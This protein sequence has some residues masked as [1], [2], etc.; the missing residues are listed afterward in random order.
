MGAVTGRAWQNAPGTPPRTDPGDLR[1]MAED[2]EAL[3]DGIVGAD[4]KATSAQSAAGD[5]T[6]TAA[7]AQT[8]A[9]DAQAAAAAKVGLN[10]DGTLPS[11]AREQTRGIGR[12]EVSIQARRD[13][14][15]DRIRRS[16]FGRVGTGGKIPISIR[17]DH[18]LDQ[19]IANHLPLLSARRLPFSVGIV[20]RSVGNP[21]ALY[22]PTTA[23]WDDI[24]RKIQDAGGEVWAHSQTHSSPGANGSTSLHDE[25]V[26]SK[27]DIE[28][29][30]IGVMGFQQPG[31]P[32]TY[33]PYLSLADLDTEA[34]RIIRETYPLFESYVVGTTRRVLPAYGT[35]GGNHVTLD[36]MTVD[37]ARRWVDEAI[38]YGHG[39]QFMFHPAWIGLPGNLTLAGLT[40]VFD[41]I[42]AKRDAGQVEVLTA[43]ALAFADPGTSYR[44]T[45]IPYGTFEGLTTASPPPAWSELSGAT[46][47]IGTDGGHSGSNYLRILDT[48]GVAVCRIPTADLVMNGAPFEFRGW[49]RGATAATN[50]R[51]RL[52]A[53]TS[54]GNFIMRDIAVPAAAGTWT[55]VRIPFAV[56]R[57][58]ASLL[59]AVGRFSGGAADWD[60]IQIVAV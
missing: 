17:I 29:Q 1:I 16:R 49:V 53:Q 12:D 31:S 22:E 54:T 45:A 43:S 28:A 50:G 24:K 37:T 10:T 15:F 19:F 55:F 14:E 26:G 8:A 18:Q 5:A 34:G 13:M 36:N 57:N 56:P 27:L 11:V 38:A 47:Q 42:V 6:A 35:Y 52:T 7:A 39:L 2:M 3:E 59:V 32:A 20:T 9:A 33:G 51:A 4:A 58:T 44:P 41:Y 30:N 46:W 23:T 48:Q 21:A 60:D 25:I 40:E